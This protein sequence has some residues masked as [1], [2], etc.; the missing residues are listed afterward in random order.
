[1][2][3][4]MNL[5]AS[6]FRHIKHGAKTV[7][8]RLNDEKRRKIQVGDIIIFTNAETQEEMKVSVVNISKFSDFAEIYSK[9]DK[10]AIGYEADEIAH[11]DDMLLYYSKE[12]IAQYG[13][14]AIEIKLI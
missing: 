1:M 9:Y 12:K 10:I 3:H 4:R 8:M 7:E 2:E 6:P 5:W 13:V 11:P 14:L